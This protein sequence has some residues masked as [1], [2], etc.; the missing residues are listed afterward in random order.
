MPN[1]SAVQLFRRIRLVLGA[2]VSL[3]LPALLACSS[4]ALTLTTLVPSSYTTTS[5]TSGGQAVATSIDLQDE[6]GTTNVWTKYVEF[7]TT[8]TA[9]YAGYQVFTLPTSIA[10]SSV[11]AIQLKVN[12]LGPLS[13][14]QTWTWHLFNWST[15]AYVTVGT[16]SVDTSGWNSWQVLTFSAT[17]TLAN[18]V[19]TSDGQ[20]KV[21]LLSNNHVDNVDIDYEALLVTSSAQGVSVSVSPTSASVATS[22]TQ[23]FT[24]TVTGSTNTAVTWQVNSVVGGNSTTGTITAAGLYAAPTTV[25]TP[26][27]V[28]VKAVSQADTTKSASASVTVTAGG[29]GSGFYVAPTGSNSNSGTSSSPWKTITFAI[30]QATPGITI[31][32]LPGTYNELVNVNKSGTAGGGYITLISDTNHGAIIDGTGLAI[33]GGQNGLVEIASQ[34]Y[35]ILKGF[36][37]RNYKTTN[38][39]NDPVG[40]RASGSGSNIQILNNHIHDIANTGPANANA[41]CVNQPNAHG[42]LVIGTAA[43]AT[44]NNITVDGNELDHLTTGCSESMT[45][46][47]NVDTFTATNNLIHDNNNISIDAA[48]F[49]Q[50]NPNPSFDQVHNG[51]IAFNTIYNSSSNT[52]PVYVSGC[53]CSDGIYVDG[54]TN[55]TIER[56][57]IH[58][59][60]I[61]IEVASENPGKVSSF[62]TVRSNLLYSNNSAGVSIGGFDASA[63][64]SDHVTIVNNTLL[65][66]D[67]QG[68]GFGE[69]NVANHAT[70]NTFENNIVYAGSGAL[71]VHN[72]VNQTNPVTI[73]YN[74]YFSSVASSASNWTWA[75]T[76]RVG[77][78]AWQSASGQDA[79]SSY[80]D[81]LFV[82]RT[83]PD[84]HVSASSPAVNTGNS[85]LGSTA[86]GTLDF[87]GN[88]RVQGSAVDKGA[89]E[90]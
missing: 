42:M 3:L 39:N 20:M 82:S 62:V 46:N 51:Y 8:A 18:Y 21:Q 79:H 28:T 83:T 68:T 31:H 84:L 60:D 72:W 85:S 47:G 40:I 45:F 26:A 34:S 86:F 76:N 52:N 30:S 11:T 88:A 5:G 53:T 9:N 50:A 66:N 44:L 63:G 2:A 57:I 36:E 61:A 35:L 49:F 67:T 19:R 24:A 56:N 15:N 10:P 27:T 14:V 32:V 4:S 81:P 37:I 13:G 29:G 75:G 22:A 74:L 89:Y 65:Q 6:S 41:N 43:P 69:F 48:G 59:A 16:N 80:A 7:Q 58:N 64:G 54:G 90:Q 87:A 1:Q 78:T 55:I 25:P 23:Q 17:G 33:P 12:Y 70:N 38:N 71:F 73:D 77:F